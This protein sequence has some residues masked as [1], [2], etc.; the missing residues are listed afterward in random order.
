[1]YFFKKS[2]LL[3]NC[4]LEAKKLFPSA[5]L[6]KVIRKEEYNIELASSPTK[7]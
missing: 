5:F 2:K 6:K 3:G 1:M 7:G 4:S